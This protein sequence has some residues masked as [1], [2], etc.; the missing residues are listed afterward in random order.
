CGEIRFA[1]F[2]TSARRLTP[3]DGLV[4]SRTSPIKRFC[5]ISS[6]KQ[7][8]QRKLRKAAEPLHATLLKITL[9]K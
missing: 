4:A 7:S 8:F 1:P 3:P 2:A 6:W 9:L 5:K